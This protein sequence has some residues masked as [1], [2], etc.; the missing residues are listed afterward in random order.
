MRNYPKRK[1]QMSLIK[2]EIGFFKELRHI[3]SKKYKY[4]IVADRG[5]C[6]KRIVNIYEK[7]GFKYIFQLYQIKLCSCARYGIPLMTMSFKNT[8]LSMILKC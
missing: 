5:F 1:N 7:L 8:S 2:M 6:S 4:T 3:L